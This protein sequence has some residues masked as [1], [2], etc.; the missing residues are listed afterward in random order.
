MCRHAILLSLSNG[1]HQQPV[2]RF[3]PIALC[4]S[5]WLAYVLTCGTSRS[6]FSFAPPLREPAGFGLSYNRRENTRL[7]ANGGIY[8]GSMGSTRAV[9]NYRPSFL[10]DTAFRPE[11]S[12]MGHISVPGLRCRTAHK[13]SVVQVGRQSRVG[14]RLR[15]DCVP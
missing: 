12:S 6:S 14:S 8:L 5:F 11:G 10:I 1:T 13:A 2:C 3:A 9:R 4:L 7:V 15:L